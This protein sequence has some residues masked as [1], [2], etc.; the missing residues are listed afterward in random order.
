MKIGIYNRYWNTFGGGEKYTGAIAQCLSEI[1]PVDLVSDQHFNI[2]KVEERLNLDLSNCRPVILS[3]VY[4]YPVE[5]ISGNYDLWVNGTYR[6]SARS[7]ARSS[8]LVVF[9]PFFGSTLLKGVSRVTGM[10]CPNS[11]VKYFWKSSDFLKSYQVLLSISHYTHAWTKKW[12]GMES[13]LLEPPVDLIWTNPALKKK[14][15]ILTVGRFFHGSHNKKHDIMIEVFKQ[16]CD[17]G[18]CPDWE[19]HLC[20]GTHVEPEHQ[21]YLKGLLDAAK[22][23]PIFFHTDVPRAEL[24]NLYRESA[25]YWHATG[26]N[27]DEKRQPATFEHFGLTAREAMSAGCVPVVYARA[28]M[29]EV[30]RQGEN[31][32]LWETLDELKNYTLKVIRNFAHAD[33]LSRA[34]TVCSQSFSYEMFRRNLK[35]I[36]EKVLKSDNTSR[37]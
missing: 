16:M 26:F 13:E 24:E 30:V 23:Y 17:S 12:W 9:F 34:A 15:M 22:R 14:K 6:S 37:V 3:N 32:Y 2:G 11:L 1:G 25:V 19:L 20:G 10:T 4:R 28:G 29:K 7:R 21:L 33:S 8:M 27:Q 35:G 18:H 5:V 31:G 36:V